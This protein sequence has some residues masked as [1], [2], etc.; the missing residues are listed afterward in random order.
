MHLQRLPSDVLSHVFS[1]L[2]FSS[3]SAVL[4]AILD[5]A[6]V[7]ES[8]EDHRVVPVEVRNVWM[9]ETLSHRL[10][11]ALRS[12]SDQALYFA[13]DCVCAYVVADWSSFSKRPFQPLAS[14]SWELQPR[15]AACVNIDS[16]AVRALVERCRKSFL[17]VV[18]L[19]MHL[20]YFVGG[21][22]IGFAP[23]AVYLHQ[24]FSPCMSV[25]THS[26][27]LPRNFK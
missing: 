7:L 21:D 2:D 10:H 26:K 25:S 11:D 4:H 27:L 17:P 12:L 8:P 19:T 23:R 1:F 20:R 6:P 18:R 22:F 16:T 3:V 14:Y 5:R 9:V 15:V 13:R 24:L